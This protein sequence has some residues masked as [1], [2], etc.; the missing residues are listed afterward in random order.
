VEDAELLA[1]RRF[2][3]APV[4]S[5]PQFF[6]PNASFVHIASIQ[7]HP[8][9]RGSIHL[10]SSNPL[11]PPLIDLNAWAFDIGR[12]YV[13]FQAINDVKANISLFRNDRQGH[14]YSRRQ[15]CPQDSGDGSVLC[16]DRIVSLSWN[17]RHHG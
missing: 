17:K 1:F 5:F 16:R 10:N 11:V 12:R 2:Y 9:S 14:S 7:S 4:L 13:F 3:C 15:I 8:F 6:E